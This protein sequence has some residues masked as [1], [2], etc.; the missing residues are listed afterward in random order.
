MQTKVTGARGAHSC[1]AH[2]LRWRSIFAHRKASAMG[3]FC[4]GILGGEGEGGRP[5]VE[6]R[7]APFSIC[8]V[9]AAAA[10]SSR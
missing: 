5:R 2:S 8:A 10:A 9:R 4:R 1:G 7:P 3:N 6:R